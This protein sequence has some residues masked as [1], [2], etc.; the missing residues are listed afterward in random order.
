MNCIFWIAAALLAYLFIALFKRNNFI[1]ETK[2]KGIKVTKKDLIIISILVSGAWVALLFVQA[3]IFEHMTYAGAFILASIWHMY[4]VLARSNKIPSILTEPSSKLFYPL[5][6]LGFFFLVQVKVEAVT[7]SIFGIDHSHFPNTKVFISG[8]FT[9]MIMSLTY[10]FIGFYYLISIGNKERKFNFKRNF[11]RLRFDTYFFIRLFFGK[12]PASK[13]SIKFRLASA[14]FFIT[15]VIIGGLITSYSILLL[16]S[17]NEKVSFLEYIVERV[18]L[19]IDFSSENIC[20]KSKLPPYLNS[21]NII[22]TTPS[23]ERAIFWDTGFRAGQDRIKFPEYLCV[24]GQSWP[25]KE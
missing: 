15:V 4:H 19:E 23:K 24:R 14:Y 7:N 6:L 22:F 12:K 21:S 10:Y 2:S 1:C 3:N 16:D 8:M 11:R 25:S 9:L 18:A 20:D 17:R 5:F 13:S